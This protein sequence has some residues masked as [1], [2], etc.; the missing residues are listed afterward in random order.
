LDGLQEM[1]R[2]S[3]AWPLPGLAFA[4]HCALSLLLRVWMAALQMEVQLQE[5]VGELAELLPEAGQALLDELSQ[6]MEVVEEQL[7]LFKVGGRQGGGQ[8]GRTG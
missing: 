7:A 2:G 1:V 3:P 6:Q 4:A 8:G 5:V